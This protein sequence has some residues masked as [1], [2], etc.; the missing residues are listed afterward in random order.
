MSFFLRNKGLKLLT[1]DNIQERERPFS[2]LENANGDFRLI[3]QGQVVGIYVYTW[4]MDVEKYWQ[5]TPL[6]KQILQA[7]NNHTDKKRFVFFSNTIFDNP[8]D[9]VKFS[10]ICHKLSEESVGENIP[11]F[12]VCTF[13]DSKIISLS[14]VSAAGY[15]IGRDATC[16]QCQI[17]LISLWG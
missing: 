4:I 16:P 3:V 1:L 12:T 2:S 11:T 9:D 5:L 6:G 17:E 7:L 14:S 10:E 8:L 15:P 13:C